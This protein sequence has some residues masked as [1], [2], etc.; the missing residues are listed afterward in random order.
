M[1][2]S[3]ENRYLEMQLLL[4]VSFALVVFARRVLRARPTFFLRLGQGALLLALVLPPLFSLV[5]R[6]QVFQVHRIFMNRENSDAHS[7]GRERAVSLAETAH[8]VAP[9]PVWDG[10]FES[11]TALVDTR[12]LLALWGIGFLFFFFRFVRNLS[13]LGS[14]L[15]DGTLLRRIG[16]VRILAS[17]AATVPFSFRSPRTCWVVLPESLLVSAADRRVAVMH[18]LQHHRQGDTLWALLEELLFCVFFPNPAFALLRRRI[19]EDQEFSCDEA[20][21]GHGIE[22]RDYGSCLVRVAE[23]AL[24]SRDRYAGTS[25]MSAASR[26]PAY[27]KS[28]LRRRVEM[29]MEVKQRQPRK[30]QALCTATAVIAALFA[31][32]AGAETLQRDAGPNPGT[33]EMDPRVQAIAEKILAEAV[34]EEKAQSGFA[35]VADPQSGRILAVANVDTS[36]SKSGHWALAERFEPA[37]I[38]KSLV[39]AEALE[40]GKTSPEEKH[41]CE[42]G[43]YNYHGTVFHDWKGKGFANLSTSK[44]I[45]QS[46][47]IGAL[48]IAEQLGED[49]MQKMLEQFGIGP[50]G[51]ASEFPESRVGVLP[52][53]AVKQKGMLLPYVTYGQGFQATPLEIVQA[54]GAIANGGELLEPHP[55]NVSGRKVIRRVLSRENAEKM[56]QILRD[57]VLT[58]TAQ[59]HG[60]SK[61]YST[62]GKTASGYSEEMVNPIWGND[63]PITNVAGFV[64]FAPVES[65][66]LEVY[67]GIHNPG[68]SKNGAHGATHAVPV[69]RKITEAVLAD[70]GVAPD[71]R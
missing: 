56:R 67:V 17:P 54:Y 34:A 29:I 7:A 61:L 53:P 37:S 10:A 27:L 18:E 23:T 15:R 33:A 70:W 47:D 3:F 26:N 55:A 44:I 40:E 51:T 8:T 42:N 46:S 28:F 38:A 11:V 22:S 39:V 45:A 63:S 6:P 19:M 52:L 50:G 36:G 69:F 13:A 14:L 65:P 41:F 24:G 32:A 66:R 30:W 31:A 1:M 57:V 62:A 20:L 5:P 48:K 60:Q 58:G 49:G 68:D 59:A 64:G 2:H 12:A 9:P 35:I 43:N 25:Y 4:V 16:R 21:I 71:Q